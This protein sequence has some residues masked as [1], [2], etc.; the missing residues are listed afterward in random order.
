MIGR[1][2]DLLV[3]PKDRSCLG[4]ALRRADAIRGRS[5]AMWVV[6]VDAKTARRPVETKPSFKV[7]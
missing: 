5:I 4:D 7:R 3:I 1:D 2:N 6:D